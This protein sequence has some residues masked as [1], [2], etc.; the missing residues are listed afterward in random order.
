MPFVTLTLLSKPNDRVALR[1]WL[2]KWQINWFEQRIQ[3]SQEPLR[4]IGDFA[5]GGATEQSFEE[6]Y[7]LPYT[8]PLA[9]SYSELQ[10]QI[11]RM[12]ALSIPELVDDLFPAADLSLSALREIAISCISEVT[13]V[14]ELFDA[15]KTSIT[16][17]EAP[18]GETVRIMSLHGSK[19][20]TSKIAIVTGCNEGLIP[21][22]PDDKTPAEQRA[23]LEEQTPFI[24]CCHSRDAKTF[25]SYPPL[26]ACL[27][28]KQNKLMSK[29]L[30]LDG[31]VER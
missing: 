14:D 15:I 4:R 20:L 18:T 25:L 29:S 9:K 24:L 26:E 7:K 31:W 8:Q 19:G 5:N 30:A 28:L 21:Y 17:P 27:T 22:V 2:G 10:Q 3:D 6:N 11:A 13:N 23:D 16:Q 1:W 12:S